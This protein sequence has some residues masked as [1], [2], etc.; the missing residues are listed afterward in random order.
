MTVKTISEIW[1]ILE[2]V[3]KGIENKEICLSLK[4][5][6]R[7]LHEGISRLKKLGIEINY[8]RKTDKYSTDWFKRTFKLELNEYEFF[9]LYAT[10]VSDKS[11]YE[12]FH[13][14][15]QKLRNALS[16]NSDVLLDLGA[17]DLSNKRISDLL[18]SKIFSLAEAVKNLRK[19]QFLYRSSKGEEIRTVH[20]YKVIHSQHSYYLWAYCED[21]QAMRFFKVV[22]I[23]HLKV[24]FNNFKPLDFNITEDLSGAWYIR[25]D[26]YSDPIQIKIKFFGEAASSIKEYKLHHSQKIIIESEKATIVTWQLSELSEF[27]SWL[28]QWLGSFEVLQP[29]ELRL[30]IDQKVNEYKE[31]NR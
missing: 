8:H 4:I 7:Q 21:R 28:C 1:K 15:Q 18:Q 6:T 29:K 11:Q 17:G 24:L 26:K 5:S 19:V 2:Q 25:S 13:T 22:R 3:V 23:E 12:N 16:F 20:P 9:Y 31:R 10:L 14:T 27:A 30:L